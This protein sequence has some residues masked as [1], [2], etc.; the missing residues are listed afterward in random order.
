MD[1]IF[2]GYSNA[3]NVSTSANGILKIANGG[4]GQSTRQL[5][6]NALAGAVTNAKILRGDGTNITLEA[7]QIEDVPTLTTSK[8]SDI[9]QGT[10]TPVDASGAGLSFTVASATYI[11]I[12]KHVIAYTQLTYP[13][14]A[15]TS[16]ARIGGLPFISSSA[17]IL[18]VINYTTTAITT[19]RFAFN[20]SAATNVGLLV[21]GF[22]TTNAGMS[23]SN[24]YLT[25]QYL[26]A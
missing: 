24:I 4:T 13:S 22:N 25:I 11:K 23:G 20:G 10:W 5:A 16:N 12:N 15:D 21:P 1:N 3:I 26:T 14:T 18:G 8:L 2:G 9:I 17:G 7:L 6:L 19:V